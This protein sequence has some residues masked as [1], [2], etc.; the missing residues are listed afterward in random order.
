MRL[1]GKSHTRRKAYWT[2]RIRRAQNERSR[3]VFVHSKIVVHRA[4][5]VCCFHVHVT[6]RRAAEA[7][8][9]QDRKPANSPE[10]RIMPSRRLPSQPALRASCT[11][12]FNH[13]FSD[14]DSRPISYTQN[15]TTQSPLNSRL[16]RLFLLFDIPPSQ[17]V[18]SPCHQYAIA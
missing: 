6:W 4:E 3:K 15:S 18:A 17:K 1:G 7:L 2:K 13:D 11:L 8:V 12:N 14:C 10:R 16:N 9:V 5:Q